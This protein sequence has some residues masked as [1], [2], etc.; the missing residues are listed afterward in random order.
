MV[1]LVVVVV[2]VVGALTENA[3]VASAFGETPFETVATTLHA[4]AVTFDGGIA[5]DPVVN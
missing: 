2:V 3:D 4:Y 1:V 5:V